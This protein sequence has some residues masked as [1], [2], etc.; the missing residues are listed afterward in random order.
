MRCWE[1]M[2]VAWWILDGC[3]V[4]GDRMEDTIPYRNRIPSALLFVW[5]FF[6]CASLFYIR[7]LVT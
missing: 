4:D 7:L 6:Q 3:L 1:R 2:L 5:F